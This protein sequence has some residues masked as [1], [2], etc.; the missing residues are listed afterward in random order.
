MAKKAVLFMSETENLRQIYQQSHSKFEQLKKDIHHQGIV[1]ENLQKNLQELESQKSQ[2]DLV[3]SEV[4][5]W[6]NIGKNPIFE[7]LKKCLETGQ[8]FQLDLIG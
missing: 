5:A 6:I 7:E 4:G 1:S 8:D 2:I 3:V